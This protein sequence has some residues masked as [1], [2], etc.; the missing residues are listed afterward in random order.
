MNASRGTIEPVIVLDVRTDTYS[1]CSS[2]LL[3]SKTSFNGTIR[4]LVEEEN[5]SIERSA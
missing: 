3:V 1:R 5:Q 4:D 2:R